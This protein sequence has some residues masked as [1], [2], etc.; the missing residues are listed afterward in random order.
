MIYLERHYMYFMPA[1]CSCTCRSS[2]LIAFPYRPFLSS[3]PHN[4]KRVHA[5]DAIAYY[6][7]FTH[8]STLYNDIK[9]I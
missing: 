1:V 8:S 6:N 5:I 3:P 7:S 4:R 9:L 2:L